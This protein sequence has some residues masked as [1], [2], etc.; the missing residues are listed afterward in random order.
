MGSLPPPPLPQL[1]P[2]RAPPQP[3]STPQPRAARAPVGLGHGGLHGGVQALLALLHARDGGLDVAA[4]LVE[5]VARALGQGQLAGLVDQVEAVLPGLAVVK[6]VDGGVGLGGAGDQ[7]GGGAGKAG[8]DLLGVG[9][10]GGG[11]GGRG[12]GR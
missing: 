4:R 6:E 3:L 11:E 7:E 10:G 9:G 5:A 2:P 12:G 1:P 8:E